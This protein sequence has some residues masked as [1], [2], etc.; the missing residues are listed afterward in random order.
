MRIRKMML[1]RSVAVTLTAAVLLAVALTALGPDRTTGSAASLKHID[2][3]VAERGTFSILEIVPDAKAAS[4]GYYIDGQEPISSAYFDTYSYGTETINGWTARL[5]KLPQEQ[6][7]TFVNG[8]FT[9]LSAG[10]I[11]GNT[12]AFPLRYTYYESDSYYRE[13]YLVDDPQNW[14][15]LHL[16]TAESDSVTGTF[17]PA[18]NGA[19]RAEYTYSPAAGGAGQ[20]VQN[21]GHFSYTADPTGVDAYFYNP[22]FKRIEP[23][24]NLTDTLTMKWSTTAVYI[25]LK[26]EAGNNITDAHGNKIY[27]VGQ[28]KTVKEILDN[29]GLDADDK[30]FYYYVDPTQTG[31]PGAYSDTNYYAAVVDTSDNDDAPND[32]FTAPPVVSIE[33]PVSGPA[34]FFR[35]ITSYTYVGTGGNYAYSA[36]GEAA[37]TVNYREIY[38]KAGFTSNNLFKKYVLG[39]ADPADNP[40]QAPDYSALTVEVIVK[41]ASEVTAADIGNAGMIYISEGTGITDEGA[42]TGYSSDDIQNAPAVALYNYV[43]DQ[44]P[45][46]LDYPIVA[47]ITEATPAEELSTLEKLCLLCLQPGFAKTTETSL[48]ALAVSWPSLA[49]I[50]GDADKTFVSNNV[51]CFNAFNTVSTANAPDAGARETGD[52]FTLA[53]SAFNETYSQEVCTSGFSAVLTEIKQENFIKQ[54]AKLTD[55]LPENV[56]VS[57]SVR[58]IINY[59]GRRLTNPKTSIRVLDLEPAKVTTG[60]TKDTVRGW[61]GATVETF[62]DDNITI[63]HMTTGEFIGKIED[64]N[65]TYDMIYIG[66]STESLNTDPATGTTVYNYRD[67]NGEKAM[68]GLIYTSIGDTYNASIELAGIR[69][70]DYVTVDGE[71]AINGGVKT[72]NQFRFSGNDITKTKVDELKK[73][74]QAGYPI[75]LADGFFT[76][77][78]AIN[79][80]TVD[81]SSYM[82]EAVSGVYGTYANVMA[83]GFAA[84]GDNTDTVIKYLNVSKPSLNLN[85]KPVEYIN[86]SS[87]SIVVN[88]NDGYYYLKYVFSIGNVTDPT[89]V[90][91][92][93]DCRLFI[94]LNADGRYYG[95]EKL[96][97]I[98][99]RRVSDGALVLPAKDGATGDEY[100]TLTADIDYQVL[101]QMP[102]HYVGIIPWKLEVIKNGA[103]HIHAS[104][105]GFTRIAAG[106]NKKTIHVLQIMQQGTSTTDLNLSTQLSSNP[107]GIYGQLIANLADFDISIDTIENKGTNSLEAMGSTTAVLNYLKGYDMLIIGFNDCYDGIGPYTAPALV[108][109]IGLGKSVLF[110]HDTTSLTQVPSGTQLATNALPQTTTLTSSH[111]LYNTAAAVYQNVQSTNPN[112]YWYEATNAEEPPQIARDKYPYIVFLS[113]LPSGSTEEDY[114]EKKAGDIDNYEIYRINGS[115]YTRLTNVTSGLSLSEF[116]VNNSI[117]APILYVYCSSARGTYTRP[118]GNLNT[119]KHDIQATFTI[120]KFS[121]GVKYNLR[122]YSYDY[123]VGWS[124]GTS[125]VSTTKYD[126][127][128]L[129]LYNDSTITSHSYKGTYDAGSN[130]YSIGGSAWYPE[131]GAAFPQTTLYAS[132][133]GSLPLTLGTFPNS[134]TDWGYY[135]NTVIRD[136]VGLDRYGVTSA[137]PIGDGRVLGDIVDVSAPMT[138]GIGTVL[139]FERSVAY[140][141]NSGRTLTV[142]EYQGYTNYALMRFA[143]SGNL[144]KYTNNTY[145]NRETTN[146]SQV[147]KGQITTYPYN[148]NTAAFGGGTGT[149]S[150]MQIGKTHE[151][152]FQINMNTDDIVVWYCMSNGGTDNNSYYDD[153]PNDCVNAYYIYN[154]GNVTYSGVGHSSSASLYGPYPSQEY[155]NEAKLFVNTMIAAYQSAEEAPDITIKRDARGTSDTNEKYVLTDNAS[156]LSDDLGATDESRAVYYRISDPNV[157]VGKTIAVQYYVSD[158][159]NGAIDP[160]VDSDVK[161]SPLDA[162]VTYNANGAEVTTIKGGHVYKFYLADRIGEVD[163][164]KQ[165]ENS[166]VNSITIYVKVT[167]LLGSTPLT[168]AVD[169]IEIKKQQLFELT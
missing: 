47:G 153:V 166:Q 121:G 49:Y 39:L 94:D 23:G 9:R 141:P 139:D 125:S 168:P 48:G 77:T 57:T 38:Y 76:E 114:F 41:K 152:Y 62:P 78:G 127:L 64:I 164:L 140:A 103:D 137:I 44:K 74:A 72:T 116:K 5:A 142:N 135:F 102:E 28:Y 98:E 118:Y 113:S 69:E 169:S 20:Y 6:R 32:G 122:N 93:Y 7:S 13:A 58:H 106:I 149:G 14:N 10:G 151:Q 42:V 50:E 25:E 54:L 155:V 163:V 148:V 40:N 158:T 104:A 101:R 161:V 21:I 136:A 159:I 117:T 67:E 3:I 86:D 56:T 123:D 71:R 55:L 33:P 133:P 70:Q 37:Y 79:T 95:N 99:V 134:I 147:N 52:I 26:D 124:S 112:I 105:Q 156:V 53:S 63:V 108:S 35:E 87:T 167:T 97:D 65:E 83:Q 126:A 144:Y 92:T 91:T 60:L 96:N 160:T 146:V 90:S 120:T 30:V 46:I 22:V 17:T 138:E 110:T 66:M 130:T 15:K 107:K 154:K 29:G 115:S 119:S 85:E 2:E 109:Y 16:K 80:G 43:A 11:L 59:K 150:Y 145:T 82:Y 12:A 131:T 143:A 100:Y 36:T 73:Y 111:I 128:L 18:E 4:F 34:W 68:D 31:A 24:T 51:Y 165:L 132:D 89:P 84:H 61:I 45:L 1:L 157:G 8:L 129:C 27:V 75:I 81:N 19:Y 88:P 162:L